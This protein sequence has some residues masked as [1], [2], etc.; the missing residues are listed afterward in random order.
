VKTNHAYAKIKPSTTAV[1]P[2]VNLATPDQISV[3]LQ[4]T[5][6]CVNSWCRSGLIPARVDEGRIVRFHLPEVLEALK[7]LGSK[8]YHSNIPEQR[9]E[10]DFK[11][12]EPSLPPAFDQD[13]SH[14]LRWEIDTEC[15][16][17]AWVFAPAQQLQT[18]S[19]IADVIQTTR[20]TVNMWL[21]H[22]IIPAY[23]SS[24]NVIRLDLEIVL[25][26]L[27]KRASAKRR[28][29]TAKD[30]CHDGRQHTVGYFM[31]IP[32]IEL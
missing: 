12:L 30:H 10:N 18:I 14:R 15:G 7:Q 29:S 26:V 5:P 4:V 11:W 23:V 8:R 2:F 24:E 17:S 22:G 32:E 19:E 1:I 31:G 9:L 16:P 25:D 27:Q 21:N 6:Q 3:R 20:Q 28:F 13:L